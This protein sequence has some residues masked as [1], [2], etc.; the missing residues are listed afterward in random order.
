MMMLIIIMIMIMVRVK[1]L[2]VL[3]KDTRRFPTRLRWSRSCRLPLLLL[4]L[5]LLYAVLLP[6]ALRLSIDFRL[7]PSLL[8]RF[9][10][11]Y[12]LRSSTVGFFRLGSLL[13]LLLGLCAL[14][15]GFGV[16]CPLSA[17]I[18]G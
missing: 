5:L 6:Q 11:G 3:R 18:S 17:G 4:L 16:D 8:F 2:T 15:R 9:L 12:F 10:L 1:E 13:A 14:S 7:P